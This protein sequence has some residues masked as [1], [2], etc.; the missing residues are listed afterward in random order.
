M[1]S[2]PI[3][4]FVFKDFISTA[5]LL[6]IACVLLI[7]PGDLK[8]AEE[9]APLPSIEKDS[10]LSEP[11]SLETPELP[12][13]LPKPKKTFEPTRLDEKMPYDFPFEED[14]VDREAPEDHF[15]GQFM[16]MLGTLGVL[17]AI[18]LTASWSLKRMLNTRVQKLNDSSLI[19]VVE[20]RSLSTKS[21][22][23]LVEIED[24]TFIIGESMNSV[25]LLG[26]LSNDPQ[27]SNRA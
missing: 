6:L 2:L 3:R 12:S 13:T 19:K 26:T 7:L 10:S 17:I 16:K 24:K 11:A 4:A 23:H 27:S 20:T 25:I 22:V 18:M 15:F 14:K 21:A 9:P 1:L 5:T 8:G